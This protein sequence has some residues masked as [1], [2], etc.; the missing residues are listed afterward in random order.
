MIQKEKETGKDRSLQR[1]RTSLYAPSMKSE[2]SSQAQGL[3][4]RWEPIRFDWLAVKP[5]RPGSGLSWY[6]TGPNSKFEFEFKKWK[7]PQKIPKNTLRCDESS[8][9]KFS[10]KFIHLV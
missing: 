9:V 10:Q 1:V 5:V 3:Q 7:I 2:F 6:Q 8:G 4:N